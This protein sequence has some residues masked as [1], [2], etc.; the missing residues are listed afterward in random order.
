MQPRGPGA[1]WRA[2]PPGHYRTGALLVKSGVTLDLD[3]GATLLGSADWADY[4]A[5]TY[6]GEE[7]H[8]HLMVVNN[9]QRV[10]LCGHG[11]IDGG[12]EAFC[13]LQPDPHCW[14]RAK[15]RR[16]GAMLAVVNSQ[17]V[18]I[19]DVRL[20]NPPAWASDIYGS[21][22]V[23]VQGLSMANDPRT[24]NNDGIDIS[25]SHDVIIS[26]S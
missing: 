16:L 26:D 4:P 20:T 14:I 24:P 19:R 18:T 1:A 3:A 17:D 8:R 21:D 23:T 5:L 2:C 12:G 9:A 22:R 25:G 6:G 15:P 11:T 7:A 13:E 10:I